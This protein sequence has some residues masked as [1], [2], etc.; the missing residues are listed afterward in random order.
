MDVCIHALSI[1]APAAKIHAVYSATHLVCLQLC[2]D[3]IIHR[4][5]KMSQTALKNKRCNPEKPLLN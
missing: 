3:R 4:T 1:L 2:C 5:A